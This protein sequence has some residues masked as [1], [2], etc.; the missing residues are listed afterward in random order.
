MNLT[1][2]LL[3]AVGALPI[4]LLSVTACTPAG[5]QMAPTS[6]VPQECGRT[7][8]EVVR[9]VEP[10]AV[11]RDASEPTESTVEQLVEQNTKSMTGQ[12]H[13][14]QVTY[15]VDG[16]IL[17]QSYCDCRGCQMASGTLKVPFVTVSRDA[18]AVTGGTLSMFRA[19]FGTGC[20]EH[21]KWGF[22]PRCGA[23]L[24]WDGDGRDKIDIFA[25]TLDDTSLFTAR[26]Q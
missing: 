7:A 15:R 22:C 16:P 21:G 19:E 14:G 4:L 3:A 6:R 26:D 18:F 25:G 12:C 11:E 8:E 17:A 10:A 1:K 5:E 23:Q 2:S 20:D 9:P 24:F 13:C